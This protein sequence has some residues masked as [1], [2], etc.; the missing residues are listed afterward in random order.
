MWNGRQ[1]LLQYLWAPQ[2]TRRMRYHNGRLRRLLGNR[3]KRQDRKEVMTEA[4]E[5]M[6]QLGE[7]T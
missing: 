6:D 1:G 3:S 7:K 2:K 5:R 4:S